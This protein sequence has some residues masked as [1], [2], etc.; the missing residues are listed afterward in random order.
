MRHIVTKAMAGLG[1]V[2]W[3]K[4]QI[5]TLHKLTAMIFVLLLAAGANVAFFRSLIHDF[6]DMA[7]TVSMAGKLRLLSQRIELD[8]VQFTLDPWRTS[9]AVLNGIDEFDMVLE[10][11]LKGGHVFGVNVRQVP[12]QHHV[13]FEDVQNQWQAY[14]DEIELTLQQEIDATAAASGYVLNAMR[15]DLSIKAINLLHA[16][17]HMVDSIVK[18]MQRRQRLAAIHM[19]IIFV[20]V[21][22]SFFCM[23]WFVRRRIVIPLNLLYAGAMRVAKGEY[24]QYVHYPVHDELGRVIDIFNRSSQH[25]GTLLHDLKHSNKNLKRAETMFRGVVENTGIGVYILSGD[26]FL[27]VNQEMAD[28]LGYPRDTILNGRVQAFFVDHDDRLEGRELCLQTA[29]TK[30]C[31]LRRARRQDGSVIELE[32]FDSVM[33]LEGKPVSLCVALDVTQRRKDEA[34]ARLARLVYEVSSEAMVITNADASIVHVNPAFTKITGYEPEEVLG[35]KMSLLS[36]GYHDR[37]FY[38]EMWASISETG[39]WQG[40]LWNQRKNGEKFAERLSI[41][42]SYDEHGRVQH[43]VGLFSDITAQKKTEAIIWKQANFD[44]LTDLPNRKSLQEKLDDA[45]ESAQARG[46]SVS[47]AYLDLDHFKEIND[48]LGHHTGDALLRQVAVRIQE[49]IREEDTV[50]RIGGDEFMIII[51][52]V[53]GMAIVNKVCERVLDELSRPFHVGDQTVQITTSI[54]V[55]LFPQDGHSIT[56]MFKNADMAMYEAK[57]QGRNQHRWFKVSMQEKVTTRQ[58]LARELLDALEQNQFVLAYQPILDMRTGAVCKAEALLRWNHPE[59]GVIQPGEFISFAEDSGVID[60]IGDWVFQTAARQA[61]EWRE[62]Y[63]EH[64][65]VSIN[66]SPVQFLSDAQGQERWFDVLDELQSSGK[67]VVVEIT[68]GLLMD[69]SGT[70]S[71]RLHAFRKGGIQIALDDFG[72]GYSSLSYLKKFDIDYI[73]IDRSFVS[74]LGTDTDERALCDAIIVMA[75]RLGLKVVAEGIETAQ[76]Q[77]FL[78]QAGCDF[79]QGYLFGRPVSASNFRRHYL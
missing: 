1:R 8:I 31:I 54:G 9:V 39:G 67:S 64:F 2:T 33:Q 69:A 48:S 71:S 3:K 72:T 66:V 79:A 75:H 77:K 46:L 34:S 60:A 47:L 29:P 36:S 32:V 40:E 62:Q 22:L 28:L 23:F 11:L 26:H 68:E 44:C 21:L 18:D 42:T 25:I 13:A 19:Q 20:V 38:D 37:E 76:Q 50:G 56:D 53:E 78:Q 74:N 27:F 5:A 14:R 70:V 4:R 43:R 15:H 30:R 52:D 35:Q 61:A 24:D 51:R 6:R 73:K 10:A 58:R 16:S 7:G 65:Q 45:I 17:E 12:H 57:A 49:C 41:N 59:R 63:Y 55:T